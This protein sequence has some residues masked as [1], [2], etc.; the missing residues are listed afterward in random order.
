MR[1]QQLWTLDLTS[2]GTP[3]KTLTEIPL[4]SKDTPSGGQ[5][6]LGHSFHGCGRGP[7][8]GAEQDFR[9]TVP[10]NGCWRHAPERRQRLRGKSAWR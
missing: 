6:E 1:V 5:I 4:I 3:N 10:V 2:R 7:G 8:S 9:R